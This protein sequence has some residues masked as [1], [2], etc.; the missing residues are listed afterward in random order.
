M[1]DEDYK[2]IEAYLEG[3][4]DGEALNIFEARLI[5]EP[6]L[7]EELATRKQME[8]YLSI[9]DKKHSFRNQIEGVS[10]DYFKEASPKIKPRTMPLRWLSLAAGL[11]ILITSVWIMN[12]GDSRD[13]FDQYLTS[14]PLTLGERGND[15]LD[16]K[17]LEDAFNR[18]KF[19]AAIPLLEKYIESKPK[20][21]RGKLALGV[22]QLHTNDLINAKNNLTEVHQ[23]RGVLTY[24]AAW[25]LALIALKNESYV[26]AKP[27]LK[28]IPEETKYFDK[29]QSLLEK[30]K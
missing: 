14:Y 8:H 12:R 22:A 18:Q 2:L 26:Q 15:G 23:N 25:Y 5:D 10:R 29:A 9:K 20:D 19:S 4:L 21:L 28:S 30:L 7:Q 17:S 13:L 16:V 24:N 11:A 6:I 1:K 3:S 27:L